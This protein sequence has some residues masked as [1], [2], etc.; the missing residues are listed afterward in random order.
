MQAPDKGIPIDLIKSSKAI[1]IFPSLLKAG[2]GVGG[3]YGKGVILRRNRSERQ[4]G[5]TGFHKPYRR[6]LR[7]AIRRAVNGNGFACDDGNKPEKPFP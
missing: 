1:I 5:T 7:L 2:F 6:K 4:M 3:H